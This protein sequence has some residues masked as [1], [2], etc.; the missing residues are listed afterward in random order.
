MP[1]H[2]LTRHE[3]PHPR[4]AAH[5]KAGL[6]AALAIA[7][8][9]WLAGVTHLPLL[10]A[11]FGASAVLLFAQGT[12]PLAQPVNVVGGYLLAGLVTLALHLLLPADWWAVGLAVGL[13]ITAMS[14]LRLTHPP[15]G[16][17]P[18]V[19]AGSAMPALE[20]L[21]IA[22]A[23]SL[24]MTLYAMLHHRLPPRLDYPRRPA[25]AQ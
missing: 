8:A 15:A 14:L 17:M 1:R 24:A 10:L 3:Q 12:S 16:A 23:G 25:P 22:M 2:L 4:L 7:A 6:G 13:S 5:L 21:A 19:V 9:G 11:P 20:L 18:V